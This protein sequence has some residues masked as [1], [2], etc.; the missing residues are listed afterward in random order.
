M[1][2]HA[3]KSDAKLRTPAEQNETLSTAYAFFKHFLRTS[4]LQTAAAMAHE[5]HCHTIGINRPRSCPLCSPRAPLLCECRSPFRQPGQKHAHNVM[6]IYNTM[7]CRRKSLTPNLHNNSPTQCLAEM[8]DPHRKCRSGAG[9]GVKSLARDAFEKAAAPLPC[10]TKWAAAAGAE[11]Q[12]SKQDQP[13]TWRQH[14]QWARY[15]SN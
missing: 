2:S 7:S 11:R 10:Q 9:R 1:G 8:L 6:S 13:A 12:P 5:A 4:S 3:T 14:L 15:A